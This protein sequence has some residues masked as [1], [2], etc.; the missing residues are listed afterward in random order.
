MAGVVITPSVEK[1]ALALITEA[2]DSDSEDLLRDCMARV[3]VFFELPERPIFCKA[4]PI[5]RGSLGYG[6][7]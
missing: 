6:D 4:P 3:P 2:L 1:R 5:H 7:Y